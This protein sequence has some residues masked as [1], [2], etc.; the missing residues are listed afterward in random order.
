MRA[1]REEI[2][3]ADALLICSPEY[4]RGIAGALKNALDWLVSS[5]EF[6]GKPVAVINASQRS[7]H[8]DAS[9]RLVLQ[10]MSARL[11][12]DASVTLPLLGL[13]LDAEGI[14]ADP[15]FSAQLRAALV[16]LVEAAETRRDPPDEGGGPTP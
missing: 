2:G 16:A 1:L 10:T 3:Q 15:T 13:A 11:V 6:P 4:A 8:A 14:A 7:V 5:Q 12:E 9:L